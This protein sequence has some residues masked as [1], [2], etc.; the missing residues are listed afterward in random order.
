L[1]SGTNQFVVDGM[2]GLQPGIYFMSIDTNTDK[3]V[4]KL[5]KE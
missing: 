2:N 5:I 3:Q 4:M 1:V